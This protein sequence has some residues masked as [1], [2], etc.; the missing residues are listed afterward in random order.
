MVRQI[1]W[2]GYTWDVKS[3]FM[4]PGPNKWSDDADQVYVD[5]EGDLHLKILKKDRV[6]CCSEVYLTE[7]LG[8]GTYLFELKEARIFEDLRKQFDQSVPAIEGD[9][10]AIESV[11]KMREEVHKRISAA[12][13]EHSDSLRLKE[14]ADH[15]SNMAEFGFKV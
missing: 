9:T 14:I 10:K 7:T 12:R 3:G 13:L 1:Q 11:A 15:I 4:G 2:S 6:W 5:S 8:Y